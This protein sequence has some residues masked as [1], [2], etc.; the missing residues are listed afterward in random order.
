MSLTYFEL[1]KM[2]RRRWFII[3]IAVAL[4]VVLGLLPKG[5]EH[6]YSPQVYRQYCERLAG[7]YTPKKREQILSRLDEINGIIAEHE[8]LSEQYNLGEIDLDAFTEHN[9]QYNKAITEQQT[10]EYLAKKC[11]SFDAL[12]SGEF[13]YDTDWHDLYSHRGYALMSTL[14]LML[15]IPPVFC[16]EYSSKMADILRT[17]KCGKARLAVTKLLVCMAAML[18]L[19]LLMSVT[20]L[21]TF[22]ARYGLDSASSPV[23]SIMGFE[24]YGEMTVIGLYIR[25]SVVR[26]V[27]YAVCAAAICLISVYTKNMLFTFFLGFSVCVFPA[28]I[29]EGKVM[30]YVFSSSVQDGMYMSQM[31]VGIFCMICVIKGIAYGTICVRKYTLVK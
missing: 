16:N 30:S 27:S 5:Y 22:A 7:E 24:G 17:A 26:A 31:S 28:F 18:L 12:G 4:E 14:I 11:E 9:R 20:E 23:Q 2:L 13:F 6:P 10:L 8:Q 29:A 15:L 3:V 25:S 21:C 1:K 19:S